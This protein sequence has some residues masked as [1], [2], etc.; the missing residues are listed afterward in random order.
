MVKNPPANVGDAS[1][2]PGL[3]DYL[4]DEMLTS[5]LYCQYLF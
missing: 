5:F 3:G 4:E 1:L 2:I